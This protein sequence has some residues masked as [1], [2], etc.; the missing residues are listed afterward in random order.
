MP[1]IEN[2]LK[3]ALNAIAGLFDKSDDTPQSIYEGNS[4]SVS[5]SVQEGD[6]QKYN[7]KMSALSEV[8]EPLAEKHGGTAGVGP[9]TAPGKPSLLAQFN[10]AAAANAFVN[11]ALS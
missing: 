6:V 10:D 8:L 1:D 2:I 7:L 4:K 9:Q 11:E 5:I 3:D